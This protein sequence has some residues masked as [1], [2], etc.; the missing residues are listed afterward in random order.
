MVNVKLIYCLISLPWKPQHLIRTSIST[1]YRFNLL[2]GITSP[3]LFFLSLHIVFF[4]LILF[5][6][7]YVI[8]SPQSIHSFFNQ[9]TIDVTRYYINNS[10]AF[11]FMFLYFA[12]LQGWWWWWLFDTNNGALL[13]DFVCKTRRGRS[14]RGAL[15]MF[16]DEINSF[17]IALKC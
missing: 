17:T 14:W 6:I 10:I 3:H 2:F 11:L 7:K 13:N 15:L 9:Q 16:L 5:L 4:P 1:C 12:S 8:P